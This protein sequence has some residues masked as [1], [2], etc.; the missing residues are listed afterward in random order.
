MKTPPIYAT[1]SQ[2]LDYVTK[3]EFKEFKDDMYDFR[4]Q[5]YDRLNSIDQKFEARFGTNDVVLARINKKFDSIDRKFLSIDKKLDD[6]N[7]NIRVSIGV[8]HEQ[9]REDLKVGFELYSKK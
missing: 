2:L 3:S 1:K 4:D 8:M 5:V 9:F 6:M 7:E